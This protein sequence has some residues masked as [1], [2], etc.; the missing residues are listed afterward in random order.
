MASFYSLR[1]WLVKTLSIPDSL[2][3]HPAR[4]CGGF[5]VHA[6]V[7]EEPRRSDGNRSNKTK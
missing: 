1:R 4:I 5:V 3:V 7:S 2:R 6:A